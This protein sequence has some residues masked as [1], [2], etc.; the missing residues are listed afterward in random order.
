MEQGFGRLAFRRRQRQ[1]PFPASRQF[2]AAV[3]MVRGLLVR[4]P[5]ATACAGLARR[6]KTMITIRLAAG[7]VRHFARNQKGATAITFALSVVP[8][9]LAAGAGIDYA[10]YSAAKTAIQSA[11]DAGA[12]S[13]AA[14]TGLP[15]TQ[16][17]KA[18][19]DSFAANVGHAGIDPADVAHSFQIKGSEVVGSARY[20]LPAGLMQIAGITQFAVGA[21]TTVSVP[22]SKKVEIALVLDYS[23]SMEEIAGGQVKYIAMKEAAKKLVSDLE[24]ASPGK[25]KVGLVPFSH[26][27]YVTLPASHVRGQGST[28]NWTGCTQ[29]RR[30]P[31][32]LTDATPGA[33]DATKWGQ[34]MAAVHAMF[35]CNGYPPRNLRIVPL[36]TDFNAIRSQLDAMKPYQYT[37]IALGAEFGYHVLSPN[38]PFSEGASYSDKTVQKFMVLLTD[39]RQTE[40]AFGKSSR[41]VADGESNLGKICRNMKDSGITIITIAFDLRE[42]DTRQMLSDCSSDP[43]KDFYVAEES[44]DVT[45]AFQDIRRKISAQIYISK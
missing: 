26:Q 1:T 28:G 31:Y 16:R 15:D 6:S 27:V 29:D 8:V 25:V 12:L 43:A 11:L 39:G 5:N 30:Y 4:C 22:G 14:A 9:L 38:A 13:V 41:T 34:P 32:N 17:I 10:R 23:G 36:S 37:H 44:S 20:A 18:G 21:D 24:Q 7:L 40:P 19:N 35:G 33:D 2:P 45:A 3:R 42:Q